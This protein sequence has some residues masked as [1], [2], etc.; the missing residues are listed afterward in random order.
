MVT[1][2]NSARIL[3]QTRFFF[4]N[5][6]LRW[7]YLWNQNKCF[8]NTKTD[9]EHSP[10]SSQLEKCIQFHPLFIPHIIIYSPNISGNIIIQLSTQKYKKN[11]RRAR[12]NFSTKKRPFT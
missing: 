3:I 9:E 8:V 4:F 12:A 11:T 6:S 10:A 1:T 2:K 5:F 7:E